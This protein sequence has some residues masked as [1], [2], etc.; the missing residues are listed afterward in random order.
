MTYIQTGRCKSGRR[1]FWYAAQYF[2]E[3]VEPCGD[4]VCEPGA[5]PH[6]YGWEDTEQAA[7]GAMNAAAAQWGGKK[8]IHRAGVASRA[9]KRI[10]A[11]KRAARPPSGDTSTRPVEYLYSADSWTSDYDGETHREIGAIPIVRKTAKRIYFD[12]SDS[13]DRYSGVVTQRYISREELEADTRCLGTCT[14]DVPCLVCSPHGHN[15]RHCVHFGEDLISNLAKYGRCYGY[16]YGCGQDCPV[17]AP[18]WQCAEHGYTW[19]HCPHG[20]R[21]CWR[22]YA[23]GEIDTGGYNGLHLFTTREAAEEYLY[24]WAEK[25]AAELNIKELRRLMADAHPDR[26]GDPDEFMKLRKQ[27]ERAKAG[28]P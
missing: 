14:R 21:R 12:G 10:N 3:D 20:D 8:D 6:A 11:A 1:W 24:R 25:E 23:S 19:D 15:Y 7:V 18:G 13:Y 22:G 27:Y 4:P 26:G 2:G 5:H 17:D 9:L 28:R 16:G